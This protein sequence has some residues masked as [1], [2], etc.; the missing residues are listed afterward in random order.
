MLVKLTDDPPQW[1]N[2]DLVTSVREI[3]DDS[4][5]IFCEGSSPID[6]GFLVDIPADEAVELLNR[7]VY[8]AL[9]DKL[10]DDDGEGSE[11]S[12]PSPDE[13][14]VAHHTRR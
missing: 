7:S 4:C 13:S 8:L 6:G 3:D 2:P 10:M 1:F 12:S 11:S 9:A 14:S 5:S